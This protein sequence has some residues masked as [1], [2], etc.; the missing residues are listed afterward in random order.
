LGTDVV[1][2]LKINDGLIV[3]KYYITHAFS[4]E[5]LVTNSTYL[6]GRWLGGG[7]GTEKELLVAISRQGMNLLSQSH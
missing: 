4:L 5:I 2:F 7:E 3:S 6:Q 1:S